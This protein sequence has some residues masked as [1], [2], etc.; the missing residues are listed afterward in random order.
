MVT[1]IISIAL[2]AIIAFFIAKWQMKKNKIVHFS[3]NSYDI[4]K[5]LSNEFPEF[6]LHFGGEGL[7]DNVMV[8]KGGFMNTGRND[9][10]AL[11]GD[12]DIKIILPEECRVKAVKVLPSTEDLIVT[13]N[14]DKENTINF[15]ISELF[16]TNEYFKY[17][18]IVETSGEIEYLYDKLVF[19]H[20][21]LNT[22]KIRKAHIGQ[23]INRIRRTMYKLMLP[24]Y[25]I[26]GLLFV[27]LS[28]YQKINFKIYQ[29]S[30][31]KE[32]KIHIDPHSNLYVNEGISVPFITGEIISQKE[33]NED[34][35]I[36]P[37]TKFRW[38][39]FEFAMAIFL[40]LVIAVFL[41]LH[42]YLFACDSHIMNVISK[43][44][45]DKIK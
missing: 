41:C 5:G 7:A 24:A 35:K 27:I 19:Q 8:L 39:N 17:T 36:V 12:A 34:Y 11:K 31:G 10:N 30:T 25:L 21:I 2:S 26:L 43:N 42:Y 33:L 40:F 20:R 22:E 13:A 29:E 4:G 23:Q 16:K 3:I 28:L 38:N 14:K 9:I 32:V 15:G 37:I 18:A 44:E 6:Q 45:K 1:T